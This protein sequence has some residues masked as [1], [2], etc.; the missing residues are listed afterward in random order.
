M[1]PL[2]AANELISAMPPAAEAPVENF[3]GNGQKGPLT[4]LWWSGTGRVE[5]DRCGDRYKRR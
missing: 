2:R 3:D 1:K 5:H 4:L